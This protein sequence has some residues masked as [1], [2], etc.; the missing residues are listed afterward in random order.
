MSGLGPDCK[1]R[2]YQLTMAQVE[3]LVYAY[4]AQC[5]QHAFVGQYFDT[6]ACCPPHLTLEGQEKMHLALDEG[7][8]T[9]ESRGL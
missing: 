5:S 4:Q 2:P 9:E 6:A 8:L 1:E 3:A 7:M